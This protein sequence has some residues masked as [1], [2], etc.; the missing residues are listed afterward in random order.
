[1][2]RVR[3]LHIIR[4]VGS[5]AFGEVYQANDIAL[6]RPC[7]AK[8]VENK[9]PTAFKA[10]L[11]AQILHQCKHDRVVEVFD[12]QAI[13]HKGKHYAVIEME[14]LPLGSV[15][16]AIGRGHITARQALRWII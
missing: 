5:G 8:F 13:S 6:N 3:E 11:E 4:Y 7:A 12:V 9:D 10:H 15:E 16:D 2:D 14:F 1:G